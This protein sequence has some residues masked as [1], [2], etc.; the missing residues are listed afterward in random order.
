MERD[1]VTNGTTLN[2]LFF[3]AAHRF[4]AHPALRIKRDGHWPTITWSEMTT[5]IEGLSAAFRAW[6]YQPG[7]R[8]AI[9]SENRPEWALVDYASL[10]ARLID[11][12]IYPTLPSEQMI[13]PLRDSGARAAFVSSAAQLDK[14]LSIRHELPAL[15]RIVVFDDFP[16]PSE[17]LPL[18]AVE[19]EGAAARHQFEWEAE[20]MVAQPDDVATIIYTSGTTGTPKGVMLSHD[21]IASNVQASWQI[22][23][24]GPTDSCLS[25]LPLSHI[26]ER[27]VGHYA[28]LLAGVTVHYATS[29]DTVAAELGEVRP[30]L[31]AAVPRLYEKVYA[32]I[33]ET[34][35]RSNA[36]RRG[37][38][39]WAR[40]V[41]G[42]HLDLRLAGRPIPWTLGL[43]SRL[44][45]RLVFAKLRERMGGRLRFCVSGGAPLN[46]DIA[47]FFLGAGVTILE[48]YG[49]TETSPVIAVNAVDM[50]RPGTVGR[51]LPG[52]EVR[53]ADDGEILTR[54]PHVMKGYYGRPEETAE[55]I[56][57]DGWLHTGDI[58]ELDAEGCLRITDRKKDLIVTAG[59]K[60]IAPQPIEAL[61]KINPFFL[62]AVMLG[63]RRRFPIMLLVPNPT[64]L[65]AWR[66]HKGLPDLPFEELLT[67]PQVVEKLEREARGNLRG[68]AQFE[69]PKRFLV[70]T[71]DFSLEAGEITPK[72]SIRRG[73][74]ESHYQDQIEAL[75]AEPQEESNPPR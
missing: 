12:P 68:L 6:G 63:D 75:Y 1:R 17:V 40:E 16:L 38:F 74:V 22:L 10:T 42:R 8:I 32:R 48:G 11:V 47:R 73:V 62:N 5:R 31:L 52:V 70:L 7:D 58:G 30:T 3:A 49:L 19:A 41:G 33:L 34:M 36:L 18:A 64:A 55:V 13:H 59:G 71:R 60:N 50:I 23:S 21:N 43:R 27:M 65:E 26:F 51:P 28:M 67:L 53:I 35:T 25:F 45:D 57:A 69:M 14:L 15:E 37:I 61:L 20:A 4:S 24:L 29:N 39:G 72:M 54:G 44:A 46:P 2:Q 9:I 66:A 56:D